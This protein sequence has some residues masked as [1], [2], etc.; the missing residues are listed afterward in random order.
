MLK[1]CA[2][3]GRQGL[4]SDALPGLASLSGLLSLLWEVLEPGLRRG[5]DGEIC[6]ACSM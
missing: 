6:G 4:A 3:G 2:D 5:P 1:R